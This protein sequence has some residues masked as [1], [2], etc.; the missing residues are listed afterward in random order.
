MGVRHIK[1]QIAK[2]YS[3]SL[4]MGKPD[5]SILEQ[6]F[7][8]GPKFYEPEYSDGPTADIRFRETESQIKHEETVNG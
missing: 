2:E 5:M 3:K 4:Y 1:P 7:E 8:N 6:G